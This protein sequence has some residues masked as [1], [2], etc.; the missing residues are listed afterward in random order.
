MIKQNNCAVGTHLWV[1]GSVVTCVMWDQMV[2]EQEA[3]AQAAEVFCCKKGA[4]RNCP[5]FTG[6]NLCQSLLKLQASGLGT[7]VFL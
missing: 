4:L 5:N 1:V 6:K 3:V 2:V 7:G